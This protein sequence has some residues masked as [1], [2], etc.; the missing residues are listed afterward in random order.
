[1]S[2]IRFRCGHAYTRPCTGNARTCAL[3]GVPHPLNVSSNDSRIV[4][5]WETSPIA[6]PRQ[7]PNGSSVY[8]RRWVSGYLHR[9]PRRSATDCP[10]LSCQPTT[11]PRLTARAA[12]HKLFCSPD[13][14]PQI[15]PVIANPKK[16]VMFSAPI[17][18]CAPN[19]RLPLL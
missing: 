8:P 3:S 15:V 19:C 4:P 17:G 12:I 18:I 5:W 6:V 10:T 16:P 2:G 9:A 11:L 14:L 7:S 13:P 1:M